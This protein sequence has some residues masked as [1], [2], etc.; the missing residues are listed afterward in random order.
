MLK[1]VVY[2][3]YR[4]SAASLQP[5][6]EK[7]YA[8]ESAPLPTSVSQLES[9]L[10]L[11]NYSKFL[12]NISTQLSPVRASPEKQTME[13]G[14]ATKRCFQKM[15]TESSLLVHYDAKKLLLLSYDAL[16]Y[17]VNAVLSH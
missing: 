7:I 5:S 9:Y 10:G 2:L 14:K 17:G 15:L 4:I 12:P 16:P 1:Q 3:G 11:L 6:I 13:I 8:I